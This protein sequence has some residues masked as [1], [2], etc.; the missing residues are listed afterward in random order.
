MSSAVRP[1]EPGGPG[2][3]RR[4][5][6]AAAELD[7]RYLAGALSDRITR[8]LRILVFFVSMKKTVRWRGIRTQDVLA[9]TVVTL[10]GVATATLV[11]VSHLTRLALA[12]SLRQ[13]EVFAHEIY[14]LSR[15]AIARH[16][17]V[18]AAA[19][20]RGDAGVTGLIEAHTAYS[21]QVVYAFLLDRAGEVILASPGASEEL[22]A[23]PSPPLAGLLETGAPARLR[24]L[25]AGPPLYESALDLD[26]DGEPFGTIRVGV[27]VSLVREELETALRR[28]GQV[29]LVAFVLAWIAA[30][31][32]A[33][34]TLRPLRR[35]HR[36]IVS[37]RQ[38]KL[39]LQEERFWDLDFQQL[40]TELR[41]LGQEVRSERL[42]LMGQK[43]SLEHLIDLLQDGV[44]FLGQGG[45]ILFFNRSCAEALGGDL[46][47]LAGRTLEESLGT[48]H[49]LAALM[50][51]AVSRGEGAVNVPLALPSPRGRFGEALASAF[52]VPRP[53]GGH[54]GWAVLIEDLETIRTLHSLVRHSSRLSALG[55]ITAEA[56]HEI[57]NPLHAMRLHIEVLK[58]FLDQPGEQVERSLAVLGRQISELD[59][60]VRD[61]L[62]YARPH[63]L[64]PQARDVNALLREVAELIDPSARSGGVEVVLDLA[65]EPVDVLVDVDQIR[66]AL[67][68]V[69]RN[70]L[71]AMPDGGTLRLVSRADHPAFAEV[72]VADTGSGIDPDQL[73]K[74]FNLYFTTKPQGSG[75]G[76]AV[77]HRI[78]HHHGGTILI[79]SEVGKGTEVRLRLPREGVGEDARDG[80]VS[81]RPAPPPVRSLSL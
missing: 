74:I 58:E 37:L 6:A 20:L 41:Q 31:I 49:P 25:Y 81:S 39:E 59:R 48:D 64:H 16:P 38:G 67:I 15:G 57:R 40:A 9:L 44:L 79:D 10:A 53:G 14:A 33:H 28:S 70:A 52:S 69:A 1:D 68:N 73:P 35:I 19:A 56:V 5:S 2:A 47:E 45:E 51:E 42:E 23:S 55:R 30:L 80:G 66:Q 7:D 36:Q 18:D 4:P 46:D 13:A 54:A 29:A 17:G 43:A 32:V 71:E 77:V 34:L 11:Y 50:A 61:F 60:L 24:A 26:L 72:V 62:E 76:L 75:I 3:R 63:E 65:A 22:A 27:A 12:D 78:L 21:G 8:W